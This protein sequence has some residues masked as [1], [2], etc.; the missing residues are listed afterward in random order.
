MLNYDIQLKA[1]VTQM[2]PVW[3]DAHAGVTKVIRFVEEAAANGAKLIVFGECIVPG[4]MYHVY[5][6]NPYDPMQSFGKLDTLYANNCLEVD[7]PEMRRIM[8]AA[9]ENHIYV[10]LGYT[11]RCN[12]SRYLSQAIIGDNGRLLLNR[13]KFKPTYKERVICGEGT[14][15]DFKVVHTPIGNLGATE[16]WEHV[17]AVITYAMCTMHEQIHF[18]C[19]PGCSWVNTGY[20]EGSQESAITLSR[21]YAMQTQTFT[22]LASGMVGEAAMEFFAGNDETKRYILGRRGGGI[23]RI[24]SPSGDWLCEPLPSD[25]EGILYADL[26]LNDILRVK[27]EVDPVGHYSRPDIFSLQVNKNPNLHAR[28]FSDSESDVLV[29]A[30]NALFDMEH[31]D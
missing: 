31:A 6:D 3:Y 14:G 20:L 22:L 24:I 28:I 15:A 1:A 16:C 10:V 9:R 21:A 4:Y 26:D 5:T 29:E 2:E 30:A 19:W 7:G 8:T 18:A 17:H 27:L 11:E 23:A 25:Q 13:R 12:G